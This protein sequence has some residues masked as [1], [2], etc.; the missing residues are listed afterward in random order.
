MY[1]DFEMFHS[2]GKDIIAADY[3]SRAPIQ[4]NLVQT[5]DLTEEVEAH[6]CTVVQLCGISD[7]TI[8]KLL[9]SQ[10]NDK[11]CRKLKIII[12]NG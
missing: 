5:L 3:L 2:L 7:L 9:Q 12:L 1:Y 11:E 6:V 10:Q 4:A 8:A